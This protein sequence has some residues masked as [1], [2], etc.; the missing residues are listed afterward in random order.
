MKTSKKNYLLPSFNTLRLECTKAKMVQVENIITI[1][2]MSINFIST[3]NKKESFDVY[4]R[5]QKVSTFE[6]FG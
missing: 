1:A 4:L 2:M 6:A 3:L 5:L